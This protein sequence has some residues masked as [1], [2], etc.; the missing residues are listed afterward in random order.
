VRPDTNGVLQSTPGRPACPV[1]PRQ[2]GHFGLSQRGPVVKMVV[3]QM[4]RASRLGLARGQTPPRERGWPIHPFA[5]ELRKSAGW[6]LSTRPGKGVQGAPVPLSTR[7]RRGTP[8]SPPRFSRRFGGH[9]LVVGVAIGKIFGFEH[10]GI[11]RPAG[12]ARSK[13]ARQ[14]SLLVIKSWTWPP[15]FAP[16]CTREPAPA[17]EPSPEGENADAPAIQN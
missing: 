7:N 13:S 6:M 4:N 2:N 10:R 1:C 14:P 17:H 15:G 12:A 5:A 9:P 11:P 8:P 16:L 3:D